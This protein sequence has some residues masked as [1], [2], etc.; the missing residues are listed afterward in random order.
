MPTPTSSRGTSYATKGDRDHA[1]QDFDRAIQLNPKNANLY[2][3]RG[4]AYENKS[5]H[6]PRHPGLQSR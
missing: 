1:N 5:D 2:F 3:S 4:K 6:R